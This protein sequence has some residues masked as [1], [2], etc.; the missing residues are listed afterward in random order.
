[1]QGSRIIGAYHMRRVELLMARMLPLH[2]MAPGA[3]F[4]GMAFTEG[5]LSPSEVAQHIKEVMES[6][7]DSAGAPLDFVYPMS[8]HPL[9]R[10]E[11]GYIILVSFPFL[12]P[13]FQLNFRPL[14][15][16]IEI[17]GPAERPH[18]QGS[19]GREGGESR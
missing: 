10:P 19:P 8:G 12:M 7:R 2:L 4:D 5:A 1:M 6:P 13:S 3:S 14:D 16:D 9:M 17:G 11:P 18:P 15:T